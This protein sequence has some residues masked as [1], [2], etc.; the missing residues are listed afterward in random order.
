MLGCNVASET[1]GAVSGG[2]RLLNF[3]D[4]RR[5]VGTLVNTNCRV[6]AFDFA[7]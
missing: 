6:E 4:L 5:Y 3:S 2:L 1:S 7:T